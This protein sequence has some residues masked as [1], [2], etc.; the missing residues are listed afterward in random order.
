MTQKLGP[1][2]GPMLYY[3][4][5]RRKPRAVTEEPNAAPNPPPI[6][7]APRC[8][9]S[10]AAPQAGEYWS[11]WPQYLSAGDLCQAGEKAWGAVALLAKAV[12]AHR[13]WAHF[14]HDDIRSV[15]RQLA[16]DS[17]DEPAIRRALLAAESLHGNFYEIHLDLRGTELALEDATYL[18]EV[19]WQQL[20]DEYTT[21]AAFDEWATR[22]GL[23]A[24]DAANSGNQAGR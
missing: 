2:P 15:I 14:G 22:A 21:G 18:M 8:C 24:G 17:P 7:P 12:A 20:P 1:A 3:L 9:H 16:D 5:N 19:L 23:S 10:Q 6:A 11:K 13:G 4:W